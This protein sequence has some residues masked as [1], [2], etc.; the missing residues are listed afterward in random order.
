[1]SSKSITCIYIERN[2]LL[3]IHVFLKMLI[4]DKHEMLFQQNLKGYP[5][6]SV[7]HTLCLQLL[8]NGC[9]QFLSPCL[10]ALTSVLCLLVIP[11]HSCS[12]RYSLPV[13]PQ[14]FY[15]SLINPTSV[16]LLCRSSVTLACSAIA[17]LACRSS[18][19][20][21][22]DWIVGPQYP[23][24]VLLFAP[25]FFLLVTLKYSFV[26][27]PKYLLLVSPQNSLPVVPKYSLLVFLS[28]PR[29]LFLSTPSL[30]LLSTPCL[31][32][33]RTP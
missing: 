27:G 8:G 31:S 15:L 20:L 30:L 19:P 25:K 9:L 6:W 1:M 26:V 24:I 18:V 4:Y 13:S 3:K 23:L 21:V 16:L 22:L 33:L 11:Q 10:L 28:I 5:C 29:L 14:H 32:L 17:L 2:I 7:L 12:F